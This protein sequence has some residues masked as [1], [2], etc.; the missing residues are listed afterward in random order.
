MT[1][2]VFLGILVSLLV[3]RSIPGLLLR[4]T[5]AIPRHHLIA[6]M[7]WMHGRKIGIVLPRTN[8][9][10][11]SNAFI[12][13]SA[14]AGRFKLALV[15]SSLLALAVLITTAFWTWHSTSLMMLLR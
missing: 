11:L 10:A 9:T 12:A 14:P 1:L 6:I 4:L 13:N 3:L 8:T 2:I 5:L 7:T 15:S